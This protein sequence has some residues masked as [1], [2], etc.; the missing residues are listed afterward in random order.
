MENDSSDRKFLHT[1]LKLARKASPHP[2]PRVGAVIVKD[3][4]IIAEGYHK[5][6]GAPH[7][8]V[9]ALQDAKLR[10]QDTKGATLYVTLEPCSHSD[11][12][13]PPC[14]PSI[15][16]SGI[17]SV[18]IG[19][20]DQNPKVNGI[21][22]L[23]KNGIGVKVFNDQDCR[24]INEGFFHWVRTGKP[25]VLLKLAMTIDGRIATKT[26]DSKYIS[27]AQSLA[28]S[29]AW[30][31]E[32]DAIMVGI[33]TLLADDPKLTARVSGACNPAR[34][35]LDSHL[36]T[37][38]SCNFMLPN[39]TRII[40]TTSGADNEKKKKLE[41]AGANVLVLPERG[42]G[43]VDVVELLRELG[44]MG[45]C[46]IMVEGGGEIATTF[47]EEGEINKGAFFIAPFIMGN[48]KNAF[49]GKGVEKLADALKLKNINIRKLGDNVLIEGY[50]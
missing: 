24:N 37:P 36:R 25:F 45:I 39:A 47:L 18:V 26:G 28:V 13:T 48:G 41:D 20:E 43:K 40:A 32:Y 34:I 6:F 49:E 27:N 29:Y 44:K 42:E 7:A 1:A 15:I 33:G 11:K 14:V 21:E 38:L 2:N 12:K 17:K 46:S 19:C 3:G 16:S 50:F 9:N 10:T 8:E 30:R 31:T 35:V 23:R 5:E 4:K 22:E